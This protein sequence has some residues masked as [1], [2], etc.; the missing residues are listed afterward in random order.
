MIRY[1]YPYQH[2]SMEKVYDKKKK[3]QK[4]KLLFGSFFIS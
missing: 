3:N 2:G 4:A 1:F